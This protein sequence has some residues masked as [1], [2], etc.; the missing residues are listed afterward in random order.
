MSSL[1]AKSP[2]LTSLTLEHSVGISQKK[3][4]AQIH[5]TAEA[6]SSLRSHDDMHHLSS[7][8]GLLCSLNGKSTEA[9]SPEVWK[10]EVFPQRKYCPESTNPM[11]QYLRSHS[12]Y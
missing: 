9:I 11:L 12:G 5:G 2:Q 7:C 10:E 8:T 6:E 4:V 3:M 1:P